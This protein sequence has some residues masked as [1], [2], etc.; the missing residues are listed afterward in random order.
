M[1]TGGYSALHRDS[2]KPAEAENLTPDRNTLGMVWR[3]LQG[4][5]AAQIREEPGCLCRKIV[6]WSGVALSLEKLLVC[7]DI[8]ADVGLLALTRDHKNLII[9]LVPTNQKADLQTS[10]TMQKLQALKESK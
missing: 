9:Q 10:A 8:F 7:L 5:Q 3:Y 1:E 6:R 2:L 4:C